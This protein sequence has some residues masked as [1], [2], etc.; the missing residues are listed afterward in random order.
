MKH[1]RNNR[2]LTL[3]EVL[4]TLII[5]SII[6]TVI[7]SAFTTGLKLYQKIGIEGQLRDDADFI[8]TMI[9]NQLYQNSPNYIDN[10]ENPTTGAKGIKLVRYND[11][12]VERYIVEDSIELK[13]IIL[14]YTKNNKFYTKNININQ[15]T[16]AAQVNDSYAGVENEITSDSSIFTTINGESSQVYLDTASCSSDSTSTKCTHGTIKLILAIADSNQN[17]SNFLKTK[18][19]LLKSSFGY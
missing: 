5:T 13:T 18:P 8:A 10:F 14:I 11:K 7:Y 2:G 1:I 9:L 12:S 15:T 19:M 6:S 16:V 3:V 4:L 17:R